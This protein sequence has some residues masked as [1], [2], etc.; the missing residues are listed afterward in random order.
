M[1]DAP[2]DPPTGA[3]CL[4]CGHWDSEHLPTGQCGIAGCVCAGWWGDDD[5]E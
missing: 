3:D 4:D 1:T 5:D 2:P